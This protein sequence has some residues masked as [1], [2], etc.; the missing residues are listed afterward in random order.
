MYLSILVLSSIYRTFSLLN[1]EGIVG[2][3]HIV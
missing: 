2:S 3:A 1:S